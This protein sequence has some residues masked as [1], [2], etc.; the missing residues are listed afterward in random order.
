M[1]FFSGL[2][3]KSFATLSLNIIEDCKS[4]QHESEEHVF[5][6]SE[7]S[8]DMSA[9]CEIGCKSGKMCVVDAWFGGYLFSK[10]VVTFK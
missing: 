4:A 9:K 10:D 7:K 5:K 6:L 1:V 3:K 2:F 8:A